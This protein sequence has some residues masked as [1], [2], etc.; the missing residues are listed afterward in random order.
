M[1][2][3]MDSSPQTLR[4]PPKN[5][6]YSQQSHQSHQPIFQSTRQRTFAPR[7]GCTAPT[8]LRGAAWFHPRRTRSD[9]L[10]AGHRSRQHMYPPG[11]I[12]GGK[13]AT[14]GKTVWYPP[15]DFC[16]CD[17]IWGDAVD[18]QHGKV[19]V[20]V[21][22]SLCMD[23][24]GLHRAKRQK[25]RVE[26]QKHYINLYINYYQLFAAHCCVRITWLPSIHPAPVLDDVHGV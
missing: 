8:V 12:F 9:A 25:A 26:N 17:T 11:D 2:Q 22:A 19:Y 1:N 6:T 20:F 18:T 24:A 15:A 5:K 13:A 21:V 16:E 3:C 4:L 10:V 23:V 7:K 14:K